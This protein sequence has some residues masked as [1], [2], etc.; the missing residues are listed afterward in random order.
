MRDAEDRENLTSIIN[1]PAPCYFHYAWCVPTG[2]IDAALRLHVND[3]QYLRR[4]FLATTWKAAC[5]ASLMNQARI[6]STRKRF[7]A[8]SH[9]RS[10]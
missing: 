8:R 5:C 9:Y 6:T 7:F 3:A 10:G 2:V 4:R 1:S